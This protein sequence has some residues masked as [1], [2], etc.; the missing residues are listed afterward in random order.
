[1]AFDPVTAVANVVNTVLDRVLPDKQANDA[2]KADLLK[3]Q[4]SGEIAEVVAQTQ[5]DTV[6]AASQS[7]FV[8]GWRPF[9]GWVCGAAF[10]YAYIL[11]PFIKTV[12]VLVHNKFDPT[13]F[14]VV[15][16]SEMMPVLLGM[17]GLG[18]ARTV[19]KING[20]GNGH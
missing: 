15:D 9:V 4:L 19:E 13:I 10:T 17:L 18:A 12:A 8:A 7:T 2:A 11:Q 14:P 3:S 6:E 1:M 20:V 16:T 5:I